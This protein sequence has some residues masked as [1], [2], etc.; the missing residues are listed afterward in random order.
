MTLSHIPHHTY[1]IHNE[2]ASNELRYSSYDLVI[3]YYNKIPFQPNSTG[4]EEQAI[5][6]RLS[7]EKVEF[8]KC[9]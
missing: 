9:L 2:S 4:E 8:L 5:L 1:T 6:H 7:Y 3:K